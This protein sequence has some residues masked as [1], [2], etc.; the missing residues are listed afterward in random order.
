MPRRLTAWQHEIERNSPQLIGHTAELWRAFI[1]RDV[2][3]WSAKEPPEPKNPASWHKLYKK[4]RRKEAEEIRAQEEMLANQLRGS[5]ESAAQHTSKLVDPSTVPALP[6][7]P[8]MRIEKRPGAGAGPS[9]TADPSKLRFTSG[10]RTRTSSGHDVLNR[11]RR[12]AKELSLFSASSSALA[13]P[14]SLLNSKATRLRAAPRGMI[15]DL[16]RARPSKDGELPIG[17]IAVP[18][19][20]AATGPSSR[21]QPQQKGTPKRYLDSDEEKELDNVEVDAR[22]S[23]VPRLGSHTLDKVKSVKP[24][25]AQGL[26]MKSKKPR[27]K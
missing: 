21:A 25:E 12:E 14:T 10:S 13:R 15:D 7:A 9:R 11:A 24:R 26:F 16:R 5:Q 19:R 3:E 6:R 1:K 17:A 22:V 18:K 20:S 23:K 8:G 27:P 4:L 2:E